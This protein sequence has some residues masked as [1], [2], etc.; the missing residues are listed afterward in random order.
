[1]AGV[2]AGAQTEGAVRLRKY[3]PRG[4]FR[5]RARPGRGFPPPCGHSFWLMSVN[6]FYEA[7]MTIRR[8]QVATVTTAFALAL[9]A[10]SLLAHRAQAFTFEDKGSGD[11]TNLSSGL[12]DPDPSDRLTSRFD[13]GKQTIIK[14]GN[15]TIYFG[16]QPQSFDQRYNPDNMFNPNG[17]PGDR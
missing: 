8:S 14:R 13:S 2:G 3:W 4:A 5:R 9:L 12:A 1:M 11:K 17:R 16:G 7:V 6:R 15:T 10:A